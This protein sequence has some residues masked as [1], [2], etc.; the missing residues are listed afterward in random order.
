MSTTD[1]YEAWNGVCVHI[2]MSYN[3]PEYETEAVASIRVEAYSPVAGWHDVINAKRIG[4]AQD[5]WSSEFYNAHIE[6][7]KWIIG[8]SRS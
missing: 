1:K 5:N 3:V 7:A 4:G 6:R 8:L 2:T